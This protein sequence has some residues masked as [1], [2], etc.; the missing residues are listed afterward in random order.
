VLVGTVTDAGSAP[1]A[2]AWVATTPQSWLVQ[3][4]AAGWYAFPGIPEGTYDVVASAAGFADEI[5]QVTVTQGAV[6]TLDFAMGA[7]PGDISVTVTDTDLD[8]LAGVSLTLSRWDWA[9]DGWVAVAT[10]ATDAAGQHTFV[11]QQGGWYTVRAEYPTSDDYLPADTH[12]SVGP[13]DAVEL[14]LNENHYDS[15]VQG[16]TYCL[17]CHDGTPALD[18]SGWRG[19]LHALGLRAP[20]EPTA[21]QDLSL[22]PDADAGLL[23]FVPDNPADNTGALDPWGQKLQFSNNGGYWAWLGMDAAGYFVE[24]SGDEARSTVSER[25]GV[26]FTYG[27]EGKYKQRYITLLHEGSWTA[28]AAMGPGV[29]HYVLPMQF[30]DAATGSALDPYWIGYNPGRWQAPALAGGSAVHASTT[31]TKSFENL[32]AGC[33]FN[34]P[35]V[36]GD[37]TAGIDAS[38]NQDAAGPVDFDGNGAPDEIDTGCEACH[39]PGGAHAGQ[40]EAIVNPRYLTAAAAT[41]TCGRCHSRG[42]SVDPAASTDGFSH[43][44]PWNEALG[45]RVFP[46]EVEDLASHLAYGPGVWN[47]AGG[48]PTQWS[49]QHHQQYHDYEW[50]GHFDNPFRRVLCFDC[51][52]LHTPSTTGQVRSTLQIDWDGAPYTLSGV[53]AADNT[54]CLG[55]HAGSGPF[56]GIGVEDVEEVIADVPS[57]A[58]VEAVVEHMDD[59]SGMNGTAWY[60]PEGDGED[61]GAGNCV[62]C[63]MPKTAKSA[64]WVY[65]DEGRMVEGDIRSHSFEPVMPTLSQEIA[66]TGA[67]DVIPNSCGACHG[68]YRY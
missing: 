4:N 61:Y 10:A 29:G 6:A 36:S 13:G 5:Q 11:D 54:L 50:S 2:S 45:G 63:H 25:Y 57:T 30:Q 18:R 67:A 58:V 38:S 49:K 46:G 39:G 34:D 56:A 64:H 53:S 26:D 23:R 3:T 14:R 48:A 51:H 62:G 43:D 47:D 21:N 35:D 42:T 31:R 17:L 24:F 27:G 59:A 12:V 9:L 20:G 15:G 60:D 44:Y 8:A 1:I 52:D 65:D 33:H 28:A 22:W 40:P 19:T 16:S 7:I 41:L 68:E 55:C 32:C 66:G 37:A